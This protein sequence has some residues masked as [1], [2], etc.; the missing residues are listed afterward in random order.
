VLQVEQVLQAWQV[1]PDHK[2]LRDLLES[3]DLL[4]YRVQ[5]D[6]WDLR[7]RQDALELLEFLV[8]RD[9]LE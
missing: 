8:Q 3:R 6:R 1:P 2:V 9:P 5:Q 7:D 4:D